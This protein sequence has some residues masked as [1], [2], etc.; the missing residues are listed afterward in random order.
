MKPV[1][2]FSPS[3]TVAQTA[4]NII[5]EDAILQPKALSAKV[6]VSP[7]RWASKVF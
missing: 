3:D 2:L 6:N 7:N 5:A 1:C 4:G